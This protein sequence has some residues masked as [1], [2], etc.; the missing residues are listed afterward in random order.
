[1]DMNNWICDWTVNTGF[2]EN[3]LDA[4]KMFVISYFISIKSVCQ[5]MEP[6]IGGRYE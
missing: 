4:Q 1:M 3:A 5:V 2:A 6:G